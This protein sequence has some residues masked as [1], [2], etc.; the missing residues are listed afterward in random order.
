MLHRLTEANKKFVPVSINRGIVSVEHLEL[1]GLWRDRAR[2]GSLFPML[3]HF[4]YCVAG[5]VVHG[6]IGG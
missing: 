1:M 5:A 3:A 4:A 6:K 2:R